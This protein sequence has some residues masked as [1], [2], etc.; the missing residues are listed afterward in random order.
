MGCKVI[1]LSVEHLEVKSYM[2]QQKRRY[3]V[4]GEEHFL[5]FRSNIHQLQ[6]SGFIS[7]TKLA[8]KA[9]GMC[10]GVFYTSNISHATDSKGSNTRDSSLTFI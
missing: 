3:N 10:Y 7:E 6:I 5:D 1:N 8:K 9:L 4:T 2:M